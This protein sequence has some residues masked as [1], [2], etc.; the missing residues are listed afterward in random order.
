MRQAV[1]KGAVGEKIIDLRKLWVKQVVYRRTV[2]VN[3]LKTR[4]M[5][6]FFGCFW[7][8]HFQ[9]FHRVFRELWESF[10]GLRSIFISVRSLTAIKYMMYIYI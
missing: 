6:S 10:L 3:M 5:S 7:E 4:K 9:C 8:E 2:P 1:C